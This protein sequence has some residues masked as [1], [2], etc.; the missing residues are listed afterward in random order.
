[1]KEEEMKR[2]QDFRTGET[3]RRSMLLGAVTA[4]ALALVVPAHATP[5]QSQSIAATQL[6]SMSCAGFD[7]N[8]ERDFTGRETAFFDQQGNVVRVQVAADMSGSVTN[9]VTGKTVALRGH[10]FIDINPATGSATWVGPVWLGNDPGAGSVI[11][12]TGRIVFDAN[13][14]IAFEAGPHD[15]I[16]TNGA[17]FC[18]AVG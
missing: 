7:A 15:V 6:D 16:D 17:V 1:M 5:P 11:K 2:V 14:N 12:D 4:V 3:M 9:S 8:I 18:A 10:I 13:G